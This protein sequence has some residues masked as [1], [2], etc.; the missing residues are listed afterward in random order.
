VTADRLIDRV[1]RS[2]AALVLVFLYAP[3]V[4]V[5]LFSFNAGERTGELRGLSMRWYGEVFDNRFATAALRNSLVVG[6]WTTVIATTF[7]TMAALALSRAPRAL[8]VAFDVVTYIA[9]I[10]PGIV[11]AIATLLLFVNLFGWL[12]PWLAYAGSVMGV[13][14]P[15]VGS[16]L[17]T[18]VAAHVLFTMAIVVVLVRTRLAGMDRTLVEAS[19]DLYATPWRTFR[20]VT[21]PQLLPAILG[22][23][24]L[25]FTFSWDDFIIAQFVAGPGQNT[26]PMYV[27]ASIRRGVTPEINA[28]AAMILTV[29]LSVLAIAWIS[30]RR[31][32][33]LAGRGPRPS[34]A[35]PAASSAAMREEPYR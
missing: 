9:I 10:I 13:A 25:S 23:A 8:R 31:Q 17:H 26:L 1:F 28:I 19:A 34:A 6:A 35:R 2:H 20:Q 7:G 5:V 12:N 24:L 14:L 30:Y 21:F 16:G 33:G 22:G 4:L 27:F 11:I 18:I 29:T 32:A 15:A 3:I